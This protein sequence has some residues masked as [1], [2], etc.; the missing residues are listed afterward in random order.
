MNKFPPVERHFVSS[1]WH[2]GS[3]LP[4]VSQYCTPE[5]DCLGVHSIVHRKW[6]SRGFDHRN[7]FIIWNIR[8]KCMNWERL[9]YF[10]TNLCAFLSIFIPTVYVFPCLYVFLDEGVFFI[11]VS[12]C[13]LICLHVFTSHSMSVCLNVSLCLCIQYRISV[14]ATPWSEYLSV[15]VYSC[16]PVSWYLSDSVCF[17]V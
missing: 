15:S 5:M 10:L 11:S 12:V 7:D 3:G 4:R 16:L 17:F 9:L 2:T 13:L 8:C 1:L 14:S 6:L